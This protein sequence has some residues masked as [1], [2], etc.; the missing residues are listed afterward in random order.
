MSEPPKE[1]HRAGFA[2]RFAVFLRSDKGSYGRQVIRVRGVAETQ[3]QAD[4]NDE[5]QSRRSVQVTSSQPSIVAM[6]SLLYPS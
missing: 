5:P 2:R 3:C 4:Q 6:G 1:T